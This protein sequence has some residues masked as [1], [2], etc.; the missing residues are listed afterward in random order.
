MCP[1]GFPFD[2]ST[3]RPFNWAAIVGT[4][5]DKNGALPSSKL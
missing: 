1:F 2:E 4:D 3:G 5:Y